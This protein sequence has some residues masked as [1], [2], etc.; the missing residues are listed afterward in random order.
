MLIFS[1]LLL[2]TLAGIVF[3]VYKHNH[4]MA[5][6]NTTRQL[7]YEATIFQIKS[8]NYLT[9]ECRTNNKTV[10]VRQLKKFL[11]EIKLTPSGI[12]YIKDDK[13][14]LI[15]LVKSSSSSFSSDTLPVFS[16]CNY[17]SQ[18]SDEECFSFIKAG[19]KQLVVTKRFSVFPQTVWSLTIIAPEKDF[20]GKMQAALR[21][22]LYFSF[23]A[24]ILGIFVSLGLAR[25][26]SRPIEMLAEDIGRIKN[27][28]FD[29]TVTLHSPIIEI[30]SMHEAITAMKHSLKA[31]RLYLPALL[32]KQLISSGKSIAIGGKEE[33]LTLFFSDISGFTAIA[34]QIPPQTL[35]EQLSSYF[36]VMHH[37][38]ENNRGT[39]DKFIGDAVMAFWG[40]P[41]KND[42]HAYDA[43]MAALRCQAAIGKLNQQWATEGKPQFSTRIGIHTGTVIVGNIG[44]KD[45]MNYTVLGDGVNLASRLEGINKIF[46]TEIIISEATYQQVK[47]DFICRILDTVIVKGQQ[48][49]VKIYQLLAF[50]QSEQAAHFAPLAEQFSGI[51]QYYQS[52]RWGEALQAL[53]QLQKHYPD[54]FVCQLY[55]QRCQNYLHKEPDRNWKATTILKTK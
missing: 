24:V 27:F 42:N 5:V 48:R 11:H 8:N 33:T 30:Q 23:T 21:R 55:I 45:R 34:E 1:A 39:V 38:I 12:A 20:S 2:V 54:D 36:E 51:Y 26:I 6:E 18:G 14:R 31:F 52:R 17:I 29:S 47:D 50:G 19:Q 41:L 28:D 40:A 3:V 9:G 10:I 49:E 44:A 32:V 25:R 43:C 46:R 53:Q 15:A 22:I 16:E 7:R 4:T 35:L 13:N 37:N